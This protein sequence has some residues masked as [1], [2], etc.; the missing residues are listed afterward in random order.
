MMD[1]QREA[2]EIFGQFATQI[3]PKVRLEPQLWVDWSRTDRHPE[4]KLF[5]RPI[6]GPE[7]RPYRGLWTSTWNPEKQSSPF[8]DY[9]RRPGIGIV[10]RPAWLLYPRKVRVWEIVDNNALMDFA[11]IARRPGEDLWGQVAR[12]IDAVHMTEQ[13]SASFLRLPAGRPESTITQLRMLMAAD[14]TKRG[15][16]GPFGWWGS[17]QTF[18]CRWAF[19]RVE[20]LG[21]MDVPEARSY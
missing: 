4:A 17:E 20:A 2:D 21:K 15:R 10:R 13:G 18:W 6:T 12:V 19:H 11:L 3:A 16:G 9:L 7:N 14:F 8:L 5:E 1:D